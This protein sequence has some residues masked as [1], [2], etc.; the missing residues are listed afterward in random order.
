MNGIV[1][2]R[3]LSVYVY[4]LSGTSCDGDFRVRKIKF[5]GFQEI[6]N[7]NCVTAMPYIFYW[8]RNRCHTKRAITT[9]ALDTSCAARRTWCGPAPRWTRFAFV[10]GTGSRLRIATAAVAQ[11]VTRTVFSRF[12]STCAGRHYRPPNA[13]Q[14]RMRP[15]ELYIRGPRASDISLSCL[16]TV[17]GCWK[18]NIVA[19]PPP[20]TRVGFMNDRAGQ[21]SNSSRPLDIMQ[22]IRN[23][24]VPHSHIALPVIKCETRPPTVS[25]SETNS[26]VYIYR[27]SSSRAIGN[28]RRDDELP[29]I[30]MFYEM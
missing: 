19:L 13:H 23:A 3:S 17:C 20:R 6:R 1:Q 27:R 11:P 29:L 5:V 12:G 28:A 7:R 16:G 24:S 8:R 21:I 30:N 10:F 9:H 18:A 2:V 26:R 25:V 14:L 15:V 22:C 4:K